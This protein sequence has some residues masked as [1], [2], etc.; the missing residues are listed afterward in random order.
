MTEHPDAGLRAVARVRGVREQD[1]RFGLRRARREEEAAADRVTAVTDRLADVPDGDGEVA[2]FLALRVSAQ[3]LAA[4]A[5]RAREALA[6]ARTITSSSHDHWRSDRTR[7]RSVELL[8]E[9]RAEERRQELLRR[10]TAALDDLVAGRW[11]RAR[12]AEEDRS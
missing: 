4:D 11:L 10:E 12:R 9:R 1:S 6:A 5:S 8:L 7:L 3:S 2:A